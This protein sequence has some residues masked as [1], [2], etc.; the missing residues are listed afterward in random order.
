MLKLFKLKATTFGATTLTGLMILC[1]LLILEQAAVSQSQWRNECT[2]QI[3]DGY[4]Y[5]D[6]NGIPDH[7]TGQFPNRGNP[8]AISPQD[9]HVR[10]PVNPTPSH[11]RSEARG[12]TF[13]VAVNG[14]MFDPGTAELWNGDRRW[15]Y[16]A[17]TGMM[18]SR[19]SMGVDENLAHVQPN[20]AYHYHGLPMGL[21]E[22]LHY[23]NKMT[24][25]GYAAD[26][27]PIYGPYAYSNAEDPSSSIKELKSGYRLKD[28]F[29]A[30]GKDGPGGAYDG[31]FSQD[32][33]WVSGIGDLDAFSGR[34]GVTPE[35][36]H[37]T[38]YYVLTSSW[39][40]VPRMFRGVPDSTF[41]KGPPGGGTAHGGNPGAGGN[42][43]GPP[44]SG[45]PGSG[46]PGSGPPRGGNDFGPPGGGRPPRDG[47]DFGPNVF[48]I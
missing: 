35:F 14:V 16:E 18:A 46:P 32:Y 17:L 25:V 11:G 2:A 42:H 12:Y 3:R 39:P 24:L 21:L 34:T 38:F 22:R 45:P 8:N 47:N 33:E 37:G 4:R 5:V 26:G 48:R 10:M 28:G 31:S 7:S 40:F 1:S 19:G 44:G 27:Y 20:G 41:R 36:P 15:A 43:F 23:R 13:G 30:S 6:S 29:R 9:Y